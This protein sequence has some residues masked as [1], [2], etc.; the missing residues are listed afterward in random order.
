MVL[1][2]IYIGTSGWSY[3]K[4][5]DIFYPKSLKP[6]AYLQYYA[7]YF[8]TT[9]IN[10]TFYHTPRVSSAE[11]WAKQVP[12]GFTFCCKMNRYITQLKRLKEPEEPLQRFFTA[13]E[14]LKSVSGPILIQL[15]P[16]LRFNY[17]VT[18]HFYSVLRKEY[19][20]YQFALEAR[21]TSWFDNDSLNLM[22][23]YNIAFVISQSG[24]VFPYAE[25]V[26]DTNIYVRFH[27]PAA[28]YASPYSY[29]MLDSYAEKFVYW[30]KEGH[31]I[32]AYFNNDVNGYAVHD[33]QLLKEII[34]KKL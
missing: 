5:I 21:H 14:P 16:S 19:N 13:I 3:K 6:I 17:D 18:E 31:V 30:I 26:T 4:W 15:P 8:D 34:S 28:L 1:T 24:N 20:Y 2:N 32:W 33:A 22:T 12:A 27:G 23:K 11:N 10:T 25:F 7:Q 29:E 9:E